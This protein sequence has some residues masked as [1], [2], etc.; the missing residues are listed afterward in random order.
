MLITGLNA[1]T[2]TLLLQDTEII[3]NLTSVMFDKNEWET[4]HKFNPGHFLNKEGKFVKQPA[5]IPF[6]AGE[7]KEMAFVCKCVMLTEH[8]I[9][10]HKYEHSYLV[11][12]CI[13]PL[14]V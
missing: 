11:H 1:K 4:P 3:A 2:F 9:P 10:T 6:S 8:R 12:P 7:Q 14:R 5:F 13:G